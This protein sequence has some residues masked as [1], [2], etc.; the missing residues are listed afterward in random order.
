LPKFSWKPDAA[1]KLA[2]ARLLRGN[3]QRV[4]T[5]FCAMR[6]IWISENDCVNCARQKG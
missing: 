2:V 3:L 5:G 6:V 4:G 1:V